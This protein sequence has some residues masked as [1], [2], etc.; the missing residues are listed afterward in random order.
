[1]LNAKEIE[2][3]NLIVL[4]NNVSFPI[5]SKGFGQSKVKGL[6]RLPYPAESIIAFIIIF[7]NIRNELVFYQLPMLPL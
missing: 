6:S 1:M 3:E 2:K 7:I 4:D 5:E